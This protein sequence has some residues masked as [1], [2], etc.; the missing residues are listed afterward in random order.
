MNNITLIF[1]RHEAYG[2]CNSEELYKIIESI[3]HEIIFEELSP[4]NYIRSYL[5]ETLIT[6]ETTAIKMFLRNTVYLKL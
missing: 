5:E 1:T 4:S 3:K 2:N 6:L